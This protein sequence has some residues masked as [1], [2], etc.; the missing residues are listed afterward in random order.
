MHWTDPRSVIDP[1]A[2]TKG[3]AALFEREGGRF[4]SG[5]AATLEPSGSGW[6]VMTSSG[7]VEAQA[8]VVAL[9]VWSG[10]LV[11]RFDTA[12]R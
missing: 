9:G 4:L 10:D 3:Y 7:P 6:R 1:G 11:R 5:D 8:A 2:L 12:S